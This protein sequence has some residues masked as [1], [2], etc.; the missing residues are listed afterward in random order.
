MAFAG[1]KAQRKNK[2]QCTAA[3]A[4]K[5]KGIQ[6]GLGKNIGGGD[7]GQQQRLVGCT[8]G[9]NS[10]LETAS[11]VLVPWMPKNQRIWVIIT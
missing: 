10:R 4:H 3:A 8:L 7:P 2:T 1:D 9:S 11:S 6:E 5:Y